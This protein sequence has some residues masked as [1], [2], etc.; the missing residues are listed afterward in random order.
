MLSPDGAYAYE[1]DSYSTNQVFAVSTST[2]AVVG[3][4]ITGIYGTP[5]SL[6][7]SP[8]GTEL[9]V[10]TNEGLTEISTESDTVVATIPIGEV[11]AVG[12]KR[13]RLCRL[14]GGLQLGHRRR[15]P[16]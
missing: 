10:G 7:I 11:C 12:T 8:D 16:R 1:I 14:H 13:E 15:S 6:A 2:D 4:P 5:I 9:W 3:S